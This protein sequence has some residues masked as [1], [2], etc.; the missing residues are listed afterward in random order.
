M[1]IGKPNANVRSVEARV[2]AS[3]RRVLVHVLAGLRELIDWRGRQFGS[4]KK[5]ASVIC[6]VAESDADDLRY[7]DV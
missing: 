4:S 3:W 2:R 7:R 5:L 1:R 6:G